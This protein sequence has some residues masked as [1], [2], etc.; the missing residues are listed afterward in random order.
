MSGRVVLNLKS[1]LWGKKKNRILPRLRA[2]P[3]FPYS[4]SRAERKKQAA[5]KLAA[6]KLVAGQAKNEEETFSTAFVQGKREN[7]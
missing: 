6:R 3:F 7:L 4:P 5:R 1:L 2:V